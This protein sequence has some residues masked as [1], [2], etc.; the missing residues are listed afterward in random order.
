MSTEYIPLNHSL[1]LMTEIVFKDES[2]NY[3]QSE[4]FDQESEFGG[5]CIGKFLKGGTGFIIKVLSPLLYLNH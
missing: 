1:I 3:P 5:Y 4:L 2:G